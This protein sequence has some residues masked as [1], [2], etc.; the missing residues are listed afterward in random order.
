MPDWETYDLTK[1]KLEASPSGIAAKSG[2]PIYDNRHRYATPHYYGIIITRKQVQKNMMR[3]GVNGGYCLIAR[4][5]T[6]NCAFVTVLRSEEDYIKAKQYPHYAIA[7][8][9]KGDY[10]P[11]GYK[12]IEMEH[13][14]VADYKKG[15]PINARFLM[16]RGIGV[17][18]ISNYLDMH[19]DEVLK[20]YIK[21]LHK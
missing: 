11:I 16:D 2:F 21:E 13:P 8:F 1:L 10:D 15:K 3:D 4:P 17:E 5:H 7:K 6:K 18:E 20:Y 12:H 14:E 9:E 19:Q